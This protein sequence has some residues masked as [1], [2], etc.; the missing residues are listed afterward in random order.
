LKQKDGTG[1]EER[2]DSIKLMHSLLSWRLKV[3]PFI[4]KSKANKRKRKNI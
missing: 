3:K 2:G 4:I 1:G